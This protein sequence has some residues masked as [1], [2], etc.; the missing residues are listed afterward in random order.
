MAQEQLEMRSVYSMRAFETDE[1][2]VDA[3]KRGE[4]DAIAEVYRRYVQDIT[5]IVQRLLGPDTERDDVIQESFMH[6]IEGA[7]KFRGTPDQLK[8][9]I[10]IIAVNRSRRLIRKRKIRSRISFFDPSSMP[11]SP[12]GHSPETDHALTR[13]YEIIQ[14]L[15][16]EERVAFTLRYIDQRELTEVA[17]LMDVSLATAKRRIKKGRERFEK[18]ASRDMHLSSWVQNTE[19]AHD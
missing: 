6:A 10:A 13:A 9:W 8:G 14:K 4:R 7:A 5:R 3:F 15:G 1:Q 12:S 17:S 19:V 16:V 2:L 18:L 11:E